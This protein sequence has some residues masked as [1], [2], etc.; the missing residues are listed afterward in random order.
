MAL[1]FPGGDAFAYMDS[2]TSVDTSGKLSWS[3]GYD[4]AA[5]KGAALATTLQ[6]LYTKSVGALN[7]SEKLS[8]NVEVPNT[9]VGYFN[10]SLVLKATLVTL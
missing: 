1:K 7:A 6:Q 8:C 2:N 3:L 10:E 5:T 4:W 9:A